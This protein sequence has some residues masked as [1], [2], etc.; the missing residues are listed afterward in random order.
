M[1]QEPIAGSAGKKFRTVFQRQQNQKTGR[2]TFVRPLLY[3]RT[4][5]T[6][7]HNHTVDALVRLRCSA[8]H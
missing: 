8:H 6:M 3:M 2:P 4:C 7:G 1:R 5:R